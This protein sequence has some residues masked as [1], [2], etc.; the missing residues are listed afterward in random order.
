VIVRLAEC[1]DTAAIARI[2]REG[3]TIAHQNAFRAEDLK[4]ILDNNF[5]SEAVQQEILDRQKRL[6]VAEINGKV[7]GIVRLRAGVAPV[8]LPA[9]HPVE[10]TWMYLAP[11]AI[12]TGVGSALMNR[13]IAQARTDGVDILWLTVWTSNQRAIPFYKRWGYRVAGMHA[14]KVGH[15]RPMAYIMSQKLNQT[16]L[17][18]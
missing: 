8:N 5:S 4:A 6:F 18:Q 10:L 1:K 11:Q 9:R 15:S 13:A 2:G 3:F 7:V 14:V 17:I 16:G 12:G